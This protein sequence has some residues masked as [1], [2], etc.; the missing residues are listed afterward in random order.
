MRKNINKIVAIAIGL[1]I[2]SGSIIPVFAAETTENISTSVLTN[3]SNSII[4]GNS[5]TS[6]QAATKKPVLTL[7]NAI[8]ATIA[9]SYKLSLKSEQITL[10]RKKMDLQDTRNDFYDKTGY[11]TVYDFPYDKLELQKDQTDQS[12]EFLQDQIA[13]DITGKYNDI[14]LKKIEINKL[15]T[16]L[17]IK[18]KDFNTMKTKVTIGMATTNQLDD[19]EIE[20]KSLQDDI[21]AKE[22]SLNNKIDYLGILTNLNLSDYTF[23]ASINY[24]VFRIDGSLDEYLDNK[25]DVYQK[26]NYEILDLTKDYFKQLEDDGVK[27]I[28]NESLVTIPNKED[29]KVTYT[30]AN[31]LNVTNSRETDGYD[32]NAYAIALIKYDKTLTGY[33]SYLDGKYSMNE[34]KVKLDDS[35]KT[36]KNGLKESYSTLL[37]L[38]NK[39]TR[40][41]EQIKSNNTKLKFAKTQVDIGMMTENDYKAQVL[42]SE[43]LDTSLRNLINTYN[44]LKDTIE[45]PWILSSN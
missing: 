11:S 16:N 40:L 23:D 39:I 22:N 30:D 33:E 28:P 10:Y 41:N 5:T 14:I 19:K 3:E 29:Y 20:I 18:T 6:E 38:E 24:N 44:T 2:M 25:I 17:E 42:K 43:D 12:K 36:L 35:K 32:T 31:G 37:D 8:A 15:K 34:A 1:T 26:Y 13:N 4:L 7:D 9:N 27:K 21:N 45:K